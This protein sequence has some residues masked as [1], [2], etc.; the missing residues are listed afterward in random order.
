MSE[1]FTSYTETDPNSHITITSGAQIDFSGLTADEEAYVYKDKGAS[2]FDGDFV[3]YFTARIDSGAGSYSKAVVWGL[4]NVVDD[5]QGASDCVNVRFNQNGGTPV[6][7]LIERDGGAQ[8]NGISS[9]T[10]SYDTEYWFEVERVDSTDT[11]TCKIY[12]DSSRTTQHGSTLTANLTGSEVDWRYIYALAS[13]NTATSNTCSG[14]VK[15]LGLGVRGILSIT[16]PQV[17]VALQGNVDVAP[18]VAGTLGGTVPPVSLNLSGRVAQAG[19]IKLLIGGADRTGNLRNGSLSCESQI[20]TLGVADFSLVEKGYTSETAAGGTVALETFAGFDINDWDIVAG[21]GECSEVADADLLAGAGL[22]VGDGTGND[23]VFLVSKTL[24]AYDVK[25]LYKLSARVSQDSGASWEA[26]IVGVASD[27]VTKVNTVG[28]DSYTDQHAHIVSSEVGTDAYVVKTGYTKGTAGTGDTTA[29]TNIE[30]PAVVHEDVAYIRTYFKLNMSTSGISY[31]DYL[32][33]EEVPLVQIGQEVEVWYGGER[34]FGG[35]VKRATMQQ[36]DGANCWFHQVEAYSYAALL[37]NY[38]AAEVYENQSAGDILKNLI[39]T[40]LAGEGFSTGAIQD[41]PTIAKVVYNYHNLRSA[42]LEIS[43]RTGYDFF[44][45]SNKHIYFQP[46]ETTVA[47]FSITDTNYNGARNVQV[48]QSYE[49][50]RNTQYLRAGTDTTD[51]QTENFAGDGKRRTFTCVYPLATVP[52]VTVNAAAKTVGIRG[53]DTG[54]DFYWSKNDKELNQDEGG[55]LLTSSDTLAITYT[56][57]FPLLVIAE[58][59]GQIAERAAIENTRGAIA[60]IEED[61]NIDS[62]DYALEKSQGLLRR[63]GNITQS[64]QFDTD[65][66]GL[67]AGQILTIELDGYNLSGEYLVESVTLEEVPNVGF[68]YHVNALS[69]E[70][71]GGWSEFFRRIGAQGQAYTI[72]ED[73]VLTRV[74]NMTDQIIFTDILTTSSAAPVSTV[75]SAMVGFSEVSA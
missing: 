40:Y 43:D 66:A 67:S 49:N 71:F 6:F 30:A 55:T 41:G 19:S 53:V 4:S 62:L 54:K 68:R 24:Y 36:P 51:A 31:I 35:H 18:D 46:R 1:V 64:V 13:A 28:A 72:R 21:T 57:A 38:L 29:S 70:S 11:L 48:A 50:Y 73:E 75:G 17:S 45:D 47:P 65:T 7:Q 56:G 37:D 26:G 23:Y 32:K 22:Q 27:Q 12:T 58:D 5:M 61:A 63:Y 3:H 20:N 14:F 52:T 8:T 9:A 33:I 39:S 25:K 42:F 15:D 59:S 74:R 69:G 44:I 60:R 2:H 10:I 16:V 34:V